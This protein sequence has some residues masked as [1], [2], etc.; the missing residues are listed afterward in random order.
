LPRVTRAQAIGE[1]DG[2][3]RDVLHALKYDGRRS[4]ARPLS[5]MMAGTASE[6]LAGAHFAV[7]VPLHWRRRRERGFNQAEDLARG[8][9]LPVL[10]IL[11]R[12]KV[13][14]PQVELPT[15]QRRANVRTA[16]ALRR[17]V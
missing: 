7:P 9:G 16:F 13:T 8:L 15:A 12:V 14:R 1:Y 2:V 6:V 5:V 4:I 10:R 11:T 17:R 3:L